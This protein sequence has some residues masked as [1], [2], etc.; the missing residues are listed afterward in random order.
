MKRYA[1]NIE[2]EIEA[3][4]DGEAYAKMHKLDNQL[5]ANFDIVDMCI[6]HPYEIINEEEYD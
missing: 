6:D 1:I 2:V 3:E 4:S 5:L